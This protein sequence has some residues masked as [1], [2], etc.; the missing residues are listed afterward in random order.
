[1]VSEDS[2]SRV[3][4]LPVR[5]LTKICMVVVVLFAN[6]S[7]KF[8]FSALFG[9]GW[10]RKLVAAISPKNQKPPFRDSAKK[11]CFPFDEEKKMCPPPSHNPLFFPPP[12][13]PNGSLCPFFSMR[14]KYVQQ[15]DYDTS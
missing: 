11:V 10:L 9:V 3:I 1:M 4:V 5:V 8:R 12:P 2:T 13:R 6:R 14:Q 15:C 7:R